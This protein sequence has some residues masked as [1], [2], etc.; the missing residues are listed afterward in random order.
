MSRS[1][2][3]SESDGRPGSRSR[4][5][6]RD[7]TETRLETPNTAIFTKVVY[8]FRIGP[9]K[10]VDLCKWSAFVNNR[11]MRDNCSAA[12]RLQHCVEITSVS[13]TVS[14]VLSRSRLGL[15]GNCL[16]LVLVSADFWKQVSLS[17]SRSRTL[18]VSSRSRLG[19]SCLGPNFTA[20]YTALLWQKKASD[21]YMYTFTITIW[22]IDIFIFYLTTC[23]V[24][25]FQAKCYAR[26]LH[27]GA[28]KLL[29]YIDIIYILYKWNLWQTHFAL[30]QEISLL[31]LASFCHSG[32]LR[33]VYCMFFIRHIFRVQIFFGVFGLHVHVGWGNRE[34]LISRFCDVFIMNSHIEVEIFARTNPLK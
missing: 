4:D 18:I 20:I 15:E 6:S 16:G 33:A 14:A 27:Q 5:I 8:L 12:P 17:S 2:R 30:L 11:T 31:S 7:R 19:W 9:Y 34:G 32:A 29:D 13:F 3:I 1:S 24:L 22:D 23:S 26:R 21:M 25:F 28:S 10:L